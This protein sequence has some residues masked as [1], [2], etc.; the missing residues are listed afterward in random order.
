MRDWWQNSSGELVFSM[1]LMSLLAVPLMI[2]W[3]I[4]EF[5]WDVRWFHWVI[6]GSVA[7]PFLVVMPPTL[8]F[9][10]NDHFLRTGVPLFFI[11]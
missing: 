4:L 5:F 3:P 9:G 7:G 8:I 6:L 1:I 10:I 11:F 2:V